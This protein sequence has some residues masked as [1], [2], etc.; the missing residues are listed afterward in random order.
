VTG[1]ET[2]LASLAAYSG[3]PWT[4][5]NPYFQMAE[6]DGRWLWDNLVWPFIDD[7][8]FSDVLDLAAGHG[9]NS[10][11]LLE[12][13]HRLTIADVQAGNVES[14]RRRF[15]E[16]ANVSYLVVN[17]YNFQ[18]LADQ[19]LSL[20]YCFDSMVH[21]DSDVVRSYLRDALRVLKPGGRGFFHHSN[22]VGGHDWRSNPNARNFMS[23]ELFEHYALKEGLRIVRQRVINWGSLENSDC[24]SVVEKGL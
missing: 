15:G 4:P 22:Y 11:F 19:A 13:A 2:G 20:I 16:L 21:F 6:K 23:K 5:D 18:P 8:D 9:R 17:G 24:M 1:G 14:C 7:S 12:H 10:A 3:D